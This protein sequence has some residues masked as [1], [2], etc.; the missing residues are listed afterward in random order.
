MYDP[1]PYIYINNIARKKRNRGNSWARPDGNDDALKSPAFSGIIIII[2]IVYRIDKKPNEKA[3]RRLHHIYIYGLLLVRT[4]SGR[5]FSELGSSTYIY[6]FA[7]LHRGV[8]F[9]VYR[10]I[11]TKASAPVS[12][13][14]FFFLFAFQIKRDYGARSSGSFRFLRP[15]RKR[16]KKKKRKKYTLPYLLHETNTQERTDICLYLYIYK[17]TGNNEY[18]NYPLEEKKNIITRKRKVGGK[19]K[20]PG[21]VS[22]SAFVSSKLTP[23]SGT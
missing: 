19:R 13:F 6:P 7:H 4:N 3:V 2:I 14:F 16:G 9:Y 8:S 5:T 11:K 20:L 1:G 21:R 15:S 23:S 17:C 12:F 22:G 10:L 18:K